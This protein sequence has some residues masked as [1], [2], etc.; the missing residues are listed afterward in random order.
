MSHIFHRRNIEAGR[1]LCTPCF[2]RFLNQAHRVRTATELLRVPKYTALR[3]DIL[4]NQIMYRRAKCR[5]LV[6]P[7][8]DQEPLVALDACR[9][10]RAYACP[11]ADTD[12][13]AIY[14][15]GIRHH[16]ALS[17]T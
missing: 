14:F 17:N 13:S 11:R 4:D 16:S 12:T 15:R 3:R 10:A 2:V 6:G 1:T 7:D 8:P 5:N 9:E